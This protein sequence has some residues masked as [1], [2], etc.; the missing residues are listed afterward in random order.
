M[1]L[2][3]GRWEAQGGSRAGPGLEGKLDPS[4]FGDLPSVRLAS[5]DSTYSWKLVGLTNA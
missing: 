1:T 2:V 5:M 3:M 4:P